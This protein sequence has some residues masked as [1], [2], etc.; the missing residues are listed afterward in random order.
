MS[1]L[2]LMPSALLLTATGVQAAQAPR[3]ANRSTRRPA[4]SA[5][6]GVNK[7]PKFGE[8]STW[9]PLIKEGQHVLT[10]HAWVG[11]R[12]MP[13]NSGRPDLPR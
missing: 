13:P 1:V 12:G 10:A 3:A 8:R 2:K 6:T 7:A 11:V 5:T 4:S 9:A